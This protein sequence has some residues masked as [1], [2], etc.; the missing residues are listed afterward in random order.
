AAP[1]AGV[2]LAFG[3]RTVQ[4]L[5]K[6]NYRQLTLQRDSRPDSQRV[7]FYVKVPLSAGADAGKAEQKITAFVKSV[8]PVGRALME[9][10]DDVSLS[11][12]APD[13]YR[14]IVIDAVSKDAREVAGRLGSE[15]LGEVEGLKK[16]VEWTRAGLSE[17]F[18]YVPY[19][20]V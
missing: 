3:E 15:S 17:V 6:D 12:V 5:T 1:A 19:K 7:S 8:R 16:P 4:P 11:V 20:L 2:Q 13:Q 14:P 18:L 9:A 10:T